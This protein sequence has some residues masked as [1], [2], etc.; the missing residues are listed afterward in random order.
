[1]R[2]IRKIDP[3]AAQSVFSFACPC[4]GSCGVCVSCGCIGGAEASQDAF[5]GAKAA[6]SLLA[7]HGT[8]TVNYN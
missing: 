3:K 2:K 5:Y 6:I 7:Q 4:I 8:Q 1:M